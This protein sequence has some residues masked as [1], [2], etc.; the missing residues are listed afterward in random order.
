MMKYTT[1]PATR[2]KLSVLLVTLLILCTVVGVTGADGGVSCDDRTF[3]IAQ[4]PS[5]TVAAAAEAA[6][7]VYADAGLPFVIPET[8]YAGEGVSPHEPASQDQW[9]EIWP[10]T[11]DGK[12]AL[13]SICL[14]GGSGAATVR[15]S[16]GEARLDPGDSI[17]VYSGHVEIGGA[18]SG[19]VTLAELN[20]R[21]VDIVHPDQ[22]YFQENYVT[23]QVMAHYTLVRAVYGTYTITLD[24]CG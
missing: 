9:Q 4:H 10:G 17:T 20:E 23:T 11:P 18:E 8:L 13:V 2:R 6:G 7:G 3:C 5:P 15:W 1:Q 14:M 16:E 19:Y 12:R 24:L 22:T 21:G